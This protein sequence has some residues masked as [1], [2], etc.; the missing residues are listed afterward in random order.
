MAN[1]KDDSIREHAVIYLE[2]AIDLAQKA[3]RTA[4]KKDIRA[5]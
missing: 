1:V 3:A 5:G 2:K 4:T